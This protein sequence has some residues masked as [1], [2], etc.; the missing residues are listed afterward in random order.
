MLST[1]TLNGSRFATP[2]LDLDDL[3]LVRS[4]G[5]LLT[6][7]LPRAIR[8]ADV[9]HRVEAGLDVAADAARSAMHQLPGRRERGARRWGS[10]LAILGVVALVAATG[11]LMVRA[12]AGA[13]ARRRE[14]ELDDEALD[15]A[16]T[17]GMVAAADR[18]LE[19]ASL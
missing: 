14:L 2:H 11:L 7:D 10:A 6:H 17:D 3:P 5:D 1:P 8:R 12:N 4:A 15:R 9:P 13:I 16:A 19:T 18:P